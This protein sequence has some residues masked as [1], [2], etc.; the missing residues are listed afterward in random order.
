MIKKIKTRFRAVIFDMDGVITNTMPA[1][2]D[3]WYYVFSRAGIKVDCLDIYKREGQDGLTTIKELFK[4]R[5][6]PISPDEEKALLAKKEDLFK[7][8]VRI[9]FIKGARPFLHDLKRHGFMLG[10]VTGT[11][12]H[13]VNKILPPGLR[14]LFSVIVTGNEVKKGKP[15]PEPYLKALKVLGL[16][17]Q[18]AIVV[19]NAPFGIKSAKSAGLFCAALETS[20]PHRYLVEADVIVKTFKD[21][22]KIIYVV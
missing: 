5:R 6:K 14:A 15:S 17:A 19:E 1:H 20:L 2:F 4:A 11:S 16:A 13:E 12:R 8:L 18:D 21:L 9:R 7:R 3:A 10:L 22:K